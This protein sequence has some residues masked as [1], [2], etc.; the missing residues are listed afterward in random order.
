MEPKSLIHIVYVSSI[1]HFHSVHIIKCAYI[2][3]FREPW[4]THYKDNVGKTIQNSSLARLIE[5][6]RK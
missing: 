5:N 6:L 2:L 1:E 4:L 3:D